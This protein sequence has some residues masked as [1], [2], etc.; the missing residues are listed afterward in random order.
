MKIQQNER[1]NTDD[2]RLPKMIKKLVQL[3]WRHVIILKI[4]YIFI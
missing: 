2:V 3:C 1:P 4:Y